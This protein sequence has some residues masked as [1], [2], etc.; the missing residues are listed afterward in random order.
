MTKF[1]VGDKVWCEEFGYGVV[2]EVVHNGQFFVDFKLDEV[3]QHFHVNGEYTPGCGKRYV[4]AHVTKLFKYL[5]GL[6][7]DT[8][9]A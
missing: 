8:I 1:K 4:L 5:Q 7:N 6:E 2:I 3:P 9:T